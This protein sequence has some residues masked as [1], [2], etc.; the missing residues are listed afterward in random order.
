MAKNIPIH[1]RRS[2]VNPKIKLL[3]PRNFTTKMQYQRPMNVA[4]IPMLTINIVLDMLLPFLLD[5]RSLSPLLRPDSADGKRWVARNTEKPQVRAYAFPV[6]I[7]IT[8]YDIGKSPIGGVV[9]RTTGQTPAYKVRGKV[10]VG[11]PRYPLQPDENLDAAKNPDQIQDSA[12]IS[13]T[14]SL[15]IKAS[16]NGV[17]DQ[18]GIDTLDKGTMFRLYVW[19]ELNYE[20]VFADAHWFTFC[21]IYSGMDIRA[22]G[23]DKTCPRHNED[24]HH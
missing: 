17:L 16:S 14:D 20:D 6:P 5:W 2:T 19:E 1:P 11:R 9:I 15:A 18:A 22:H 7:A 24:D 23:A 3:N 4:T 13:P 8:D 21:Y 12:L 10:S